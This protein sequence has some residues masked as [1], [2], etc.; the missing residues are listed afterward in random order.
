MHKSNEVAYEMDVHT[1]AI[2]QLNNELDDAES[3]YKYAM[4]AKHLGDTVLAALFL[5]NAK[6][7][8]THYQGLA[9]AVEKSIPNIKT[10]PL[11]PLMENLEEW[12]ECIEKDIASIKAS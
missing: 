2:E 10:N 4:K 9:D 5:S 6:G 8:L 12:A 7:E 1:F 11:Y 3:Y